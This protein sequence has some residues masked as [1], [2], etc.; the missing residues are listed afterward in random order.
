MGH[1]Q[2][3]IEGL[4][5]RALENHLR[6]VLFAGPEG[7]A[8]LTSAN[9]KSATSRD[10]A[11]E[12]EFDAGGESG[13]LEVRQA[14]VAVGRAASVDRLGLE[15]ADVALEG[16]YISIDE[17]YRTSSPSIYA[18]GD[19]VGP[20]LLAHAA[21]AEGVAAVEM[22]SGKGHGPVDPRNIPSCIYCQP[23]VATIG[24]T[25]EEAE[26][27]G[28]SV[29]IGRFPFRASGRAAASGDEE[30]FVKL[31]ADAKYGEILGA[32]LIGKG[33]TELIAEIGLVQRMEAT[34]REL[35]STVHAHPT[36]AETL[37]EAALDLD[38]MTLNI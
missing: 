29:K 37:G 14:L 32:H 18:I 1:L 38:K 24:L 35:Q 21:S 16:G 33:T 4:E 17:Q 25:E 8:V 20:P 9:L 31:V 22:M 19:V 3:Q 15:D 36:L 12:L 34:A 23:E 28:I 13:K 11:V 2:R 26:A 27:K 10:G 7:I 30:G 5:D 6:S